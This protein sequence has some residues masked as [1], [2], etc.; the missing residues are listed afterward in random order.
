MSPKQATLK[1][2]D[3]NAA[4]LQR[5]LAPSPRQE[6]SVISCCLTHTYTLFFFMLLKKCVAFPSLCLTHI[7]A[8]K[9]MHQSFPI[10]SVFKATDLLHSVYSERSGGVCL[11]SYEW[12]NT[13][14][15]SNSHTPAIAANLWCIAEGLMLPGFIIFFQ[16]CYF[17]REHVRCLHLWTDV[18]ITA[19]FT[20]DRE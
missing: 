9:I 14:L 2:T 1:R 7:L 15:S 16:R 13:L 17:T 18:S 19:G 10:H 12:C 6:Y 4:C 11:C 5:P 20:V 3:R 8:N